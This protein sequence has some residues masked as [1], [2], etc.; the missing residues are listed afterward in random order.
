MQSIPLLLLSSLHCLAMSC[1]ALHSQQTILVS[2]YNSQISSYTLSQSDSG[3]FLEQAGV[4]DVDRDMT[5]LQVEGDM[6]YAA[7]E[8]ESYGGVAGGAISRWNMTKDGMQKLEVISLPTASPAHLLVSLDQDLA[9]CANYGGHSWSAINMDKGKLGSVAYHETFDAGCRDA[10]HPHQTVMYG[11][12]VWVVDLGCDTIWHYK[13]ENKEVVKLG[14]TAVKAGSGPRHMVVHDQR[15]LVF[16]V[17]EIMS[18][19]EVYRLNE[20][21]GSLNLLQQVELSPHE[22]DYG[23]EILLGPDGHHVYA[24]SRGSGLVLVYRLGGDDRLVKIQ[25]FYLGGT[26]PRHFAIQGD[27]MVVADQRG[28]SVQLVDINRDTG[29]LTGGD[30]VKTKEMPAFVCFVD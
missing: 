17:G 6:V 8:V 11:P 10:S 15:K 22:E 30:M 5:W 12:W 25:E 1:A 23:A 19:V 20:T 26:W 24:S 28:D 16:L 9:F 21:D 13:V 18:L 3:T 14:K 27:M 4:F 29:E 7:H 2:G